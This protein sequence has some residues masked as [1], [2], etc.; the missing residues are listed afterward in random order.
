LY[1]YKSGV[2]HHV[3]KV[4]APGAFEEVNHAVTITGWGVTE[5][6]VKYWI[7]KNSWGT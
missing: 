1:H 4:Q 3:K 2:Y 6:G 5:D 7:V